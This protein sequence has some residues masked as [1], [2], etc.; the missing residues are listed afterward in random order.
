MENLNIA[1]IDWAIKF[2]K[3]RTVPLKSISGWLKY[4]R[5]RC[6]FCHGLIPADEVLLL[7]ESLKDGSHRNTQKHLDDIGYFDNGF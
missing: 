2:I 5:L 7:L 3:T 4:R 6:I 1:D